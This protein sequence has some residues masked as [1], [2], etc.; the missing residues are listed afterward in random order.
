ME[1]LEWIYEW[2]QELRLSYAFGLWDG[3]TDKAYFVGEYDETEPQTE[4]GLLE[5]TFILNGFTS[6]SWMEL[7]Q[8]KEKIRSSLP[9][10][11]IRGG[12]GMAVLYAGA[13]IIPL[14]DMSLKRI[15]IN[16]TCKKWSV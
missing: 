8:A 5:S 2:M 9:Q 1:L 13:Q 3:K 14:D 4:D 12:A 16:L 11:F 7:E 6:G 10:T 15:Q